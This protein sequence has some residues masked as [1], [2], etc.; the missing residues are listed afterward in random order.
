MTGEYEAKED[1]M[2]MYLNKDKNMSTTLAE[3]KIQ[4]VLR[5]ENTQADALAR[6][7][8]SVEGLAP[9][10][11]MWEVL[12]EPS[13]NMLAVNYLDRSNTWMDQ[14]VAYNRSHQLPEDE[15]EASQ[16]KKHA[17][18]FVWYEDNLYKKSYTHPLLRCITPEDGDYVLREIH[19][20]G[21]W[22]PPRVS[23]HRWKS[24]Q[25]RVLL[26]NPPS[27]RREASPSLQKVSKVCS[28]PTPTFQQTHSHHCYITLRSVGHGPPRPFPCCH[29]AKEIFLVAIDYF[30]KWIKAEPLAFIIDKQI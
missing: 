1:S 20:R 19:Q 11:I 4:H 8:S 22:K 30:T 15:K 16:V 29:M 24:T 26:A 21:M 18:W 13:I 2:R 9:R 25:S 17:E 14:I 5:G 7:A 23:N 3:F 12:K 28:S 27:R 6:M 10:T